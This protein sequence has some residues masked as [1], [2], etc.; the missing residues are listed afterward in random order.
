MAT[1]VSL[2][3][4]SSLAFNASIVF[5]RFAMT[6]IWVPTN[7]SNR[8][9]FDSSSASLFDLWDWTEVVVDV[10]GELLAADKRVWT[11][12]RRSRS[13]FSISGSR[14]EMDA[15]R[16]I[17]GELTVDGFARLFPEAAEA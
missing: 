4:L 6:S 11:W 15:V 13:S 17:V 3:S 12:I 16:D 10:P 14:V 2:P 1:E 5:C 9:I 7:D 8:D